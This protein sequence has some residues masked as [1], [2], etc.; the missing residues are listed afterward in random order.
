MLPAYVLLD[1]E[2]TGATPL[3]DRITEIGLIRYEG[4]VEV[5]RWQTLVNP[6]MNISYFIQ[7]IT[8]ITNEMV[9]DAPL[10]KDVAA[11]LITYLEGAVLCAHNV[12]FDHGFLKSEFK[13]LGITLR[14][15]VLCT[16]KLSRLLY[17]E[18]KSHGLDAIIQRHNIA[19]SSRHRAMGDVEVMSAFLEIAEREHGVYRLEQMASQLLKGQSLPAGIN[20]QLL[21][22][23]PETPGIYIFYGDNT[24]P[25]YVGKSVNIRS[26]VLSH[27]SSDHARTKS[28]RISQEIKHIEWIETAG[29]FGALLLESRLIKER[30]PIYNRQLRR[31]R[32]LCSWKLSGSPTQTPLLTLVNHDEITP[33]SL[34]QSYGAYRSKRQ[35]IAALRQIVEAHHLCPQWVGLEPGQGP[36]FAFQLKRCKGVCCDRESPDIHYLR[37]KQALI[38]QQLKY[39][40]YPGKIGIKES[41]ADNGKSAI[42]VFEHWNY[43]GSVEDEPACAELL[44]SKTDFYFD[45]DSYKLLLK[46]L[47]KAK[48]NIIQL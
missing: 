19:C 42:H 32:Q 2:T 33:E 36:C 15:Q 31:E 3:T 47:G 22:E 28:M 21:E 13:R 44:M 4:G 6:E 37:L 20:P 38:A 7:G 5:S 48:L 34:G 35:A 11:D 17:P 40:P 9:K 14:Q 18:Y 46:E 27:F 43:L 23:M 45:L 16:V 8:G 29:E 1:L 25:L 30:Q 26:R 39:W 41:N 12:R 10:F 24:L